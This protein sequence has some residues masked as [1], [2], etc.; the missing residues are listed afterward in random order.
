MRKQEHDTAYV[1]KLNAKKAELKKSKFKTWEV[2][3]METILES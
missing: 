1:G 2:L 3:I